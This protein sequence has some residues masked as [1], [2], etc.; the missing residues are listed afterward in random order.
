[1]LYDQHREQHNGKGLQCT[2]CDRAFIKMGSASLHLSKTHKSKD[3]SLLREVTLHRGEVVDPHALHDV[4]L[5]DE[6]EAFEVGIYSTKVRTDFWSCYFCKRYF[7][8]IAGEWRGAQV[9]SLHLL[10]S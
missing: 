5:G 7:L 10:V 4:S 9:S 6:N 3:Q 2:L 1:M 8:L